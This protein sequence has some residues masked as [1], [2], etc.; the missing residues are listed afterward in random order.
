M[1]R[2][3][4][5]Q[6]AQKQG[7]S[8]RLAKALAIVGIGLAFAAT[9]TILIYVFAAVAEIA[10]VP[11]GLLL[12]PIAMAYCNLGNLVAARRPRNPIGWIFLAVGLLYTVT[13]VSEA[14]DRTLRSYRRQHGA[15]LRAGAH[16]YILKDAEEAEMV[17]AIRAVGGGEAIFSPAIATRLVDN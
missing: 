5:D 4:L 14:Y 10:V 6:A 8:N 2:P 13:M 17:R 9:F 1:K 7:T 12:G 3:L 16:G 11:I 15:A